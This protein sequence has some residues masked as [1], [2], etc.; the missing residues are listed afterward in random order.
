MVCKLLKCKG[1]LQVLSLLI[2]MSTFVEVCFSKL[3]KKLT[4]HLS[5]TTANVHYVDTSLANLQS[6]LSM[7]TAGWQLIK[8]DQPKSRHTKYTKWISWTYSLALEFDFF[9]LRW[10][11]EVCLLHIDSSSFVWKLKMYCKIQWTI[12]FRG[13]RFF[14]QV[15][16][17]LYR[18]F[19]SQ[20]YL[21]PSCYPYC[22]SAVYDIAE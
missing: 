11:F 22:R 21:T 20:K 3:L 18:Y 6:N 1:T 13:L 4:S 8:Y 12:G 19:T 15:I 16:I 14:G 10:L 7:E 2:C 9:S 17:L 5:S